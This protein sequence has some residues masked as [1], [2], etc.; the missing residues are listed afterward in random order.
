MT[1]KPTLDAF[2]DKHRLPSVFTESAE[3]CYLP[4]ADWLHR[5]IAD[6]QGDG[7]TDAFVL[8]INGAQGTGKST[9][10]DLLATV[11]GEQHGYRIVVLSIDDLY[12]TKAEREAMARDVHPMFATRGV[13]GT[14]DVELG[15]RTIDALHALKQGETLRV[16]RFDKSVDDRYPASNWT[17]VTGPID[18]VIFE[19]WC[20]GS[21]PA[22]DAA[23]LEP[24]NALEAE[25]DADG[26][27]RRTV[28]TALASDYRRLF[29]LLDRLVLLRAPDFDCVHRWRLEQ[30]HKLREAAGDAAG[31]MSDAEVATFIEYYERITRDNL[32]RLEDRANVV[33]GLADDH[34]A[35]SFRA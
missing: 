24:V 17:E 27:W 4:C 26:S 1:A 34:S 21:R 2:L 14:H 18:A 35:V 30:E 22:E 28:N 11:L 8:G 25:R 12:K 16:P 15:I 9:L 20:V 33:I 23:L 10:A 3:R 7:L 19:G 31:V 5:Q 29:A 32:M 6:H 13:P